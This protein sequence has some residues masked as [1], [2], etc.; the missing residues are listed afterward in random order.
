LR[1]L[2][3]LSKSGL[4]DL[5]YGDESRVS[6]EPCVPYGWQFA[7]EEVFMSAAKGAGLNC[8][9]LLS[10]SNDLL[11]ETTRQRITGRFII[12]Q[13]ERLSFS[14]RKTTVVVLD[15]ARVHTSQQ[16][17]KRR[18]FWQQRGLFIFYLPPY[19]PHLNLAETLWRKLKYEWL[20]PADYATADG[21]FYR[22]RQALAAVGTSL[23][24]RFSEFSLG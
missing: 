16:V 5:Y 2:E 19:S 7:G 24:I 14:A 1:E 12:E 17:Q 6:L 15:N 20:E 11:F 22:V 4:I 9:A 23:K 3:Q 10:R 13:F 18:P 8:F 21:L